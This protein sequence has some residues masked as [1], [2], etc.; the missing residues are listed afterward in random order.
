LIDTLAMGGA[1]QV[2]VI[3]AGELAQRGHAVTVVAYHPVNDFVERLN[4]DG[5][6][7]VL[8]SGHKPSR[9]VQLRRIFRQRKFDVVHAFKAPAVVWGICST[10]GLEQPRWFGGHHALTSE[11]RAVRW[12]CRLLDRRLEGWIVPSRA[13][14][15]LVLRDFTRDSSRVHVVPNPVNLAAFQ[16]QRTTTEAK[17]ALGIAP[18]TAVVTM[19][20]NLHPWKN[21]PFFLQV[22]RRVVDAGR[23]VL[24]LSVGRD[25]LG[26]AVQAECTARGLGGHVR[27]LGHVA[28]VARVLEATDVAII[29]SEQESFC[30]ALAEA[31]AM[32]VACVSTDNGGASEVLADGETGLIVPRD[33]EGALADA[34]LRLLHD[35][36]KR[37][38]MGEAAQRRAR[39]L[40][41]PETFADRLEEIYT[42]AARA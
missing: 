10:A 13:T 23:D 34:V 33:D 25:G 5:V 20:A 30:L 29:T 11:S 8:L 4:E 7:T 28:D 22:A 38:A 3:C 39:R 26:G 6:E 15:G 1:E 32:G 12:L 41:S 18:D 36:A 9:L 37:A 31:G 17:Q 21:Y 14:A 27:F 24:F 2:A 42:R 35:A 16:R 19:V 40:F